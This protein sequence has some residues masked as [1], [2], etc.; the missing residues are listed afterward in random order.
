MKA[1][2]AT[3]P[4][5]FSRDFLPVEGFSIILDDLHA[6]VLVLESGIRIAMLVL[7]MTS[8]PANEI[9]ALNTILQT[10]TGAGKCF[11]LV[12]HTFSAPHF[13]PDHMLKTEAERD[14]N[15][16]LKQT[17]Y[18]AVKGAAKEAVQKLG[19]VS[20]SVGNAQC[21]VNTSRDVETPNG[22]WIA[23]NGNGMVDH[24]M[25]AIRF[26]YENGRDAVILV[27]YPVQSSV[28]DGSKLREGGK[29]VSGDLAGQMAGILEHELDCPVM[30][31]LGAA[32]DQAPRQKAVS[33]TVGENG[34]LLPRDMQNDAIR[35]CRDLAA[36]MADSAKEALHIG[37][38]ADCDTVRWRQTLVTVPAKKME[39]DLHMLRPTR[40]S[41]YEPDKDSIQTLDLLQIGDLKL[42]GVKPELNCV[43]AQ[44]IGGDDAMVKVVTMWNG[45]AKYMADATSYDRITYE[46]QNSP[47]MKGAAELIMLAARD[48]LERTT[49]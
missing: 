40:I 25:T 13:M 31:L 33:F 23:N 30:F 43:T 3:R 28:L 35:I 47:F 41:H 14:K 18:D 6:R 38:P 17:L 27:H 49:D 19:A 46:A 22:W 15:E 36:E 32:G 26:T 11:S 12:V 34:E 21:M 2:A 9:E 16:L 29:V 24:T 4:L 5:I 37:Q 7:E 48:L 10:E 44:Q 39:P 8:L 1:G 42:I 45:G 20:M